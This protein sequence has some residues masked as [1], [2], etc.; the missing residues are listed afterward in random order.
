MVTRRAFLAYSGGTA[1]TLFLVG[2]NGIPQAVGQVAGGSLDPATV[3][4]FR[5]PLLAPPVMP[6]HGRLTAKGGRN[7]DYYEISMRQFSQQILPAGMPQTTVWGYGPARAPRRGTAI[8]HAPSLTIE[9]KWETPIRIKWV[10]ELVAA[11]GTYLP[12]LLPVDPTLHWAN[13]GRVPDE[14]GRARTDIRPSYAGKTYVAPAD[15]T[16]PTTQY[17]DYRGP[18]PIVAHVHGAVGV[19]EESDGYPEAWFLPVAA[20][21]PADHATVGHWYDF[22]AATFAATFGETW[23][24]GFSISHYPNLNRAST[25]WYHDHTLGM[26]RLN[27]Y[28]G[29]AGFFIL[30]GGPSGDGAV[31][32]S[33]TA[34]PAV[35]PGP[36][37]KEGDKATKTYRE[38]PLAIQDRSFNADG[39]L[40]Y[41]DTRAF[42]DEL[43]P[44]YIP[45]SDVSPVWNPEFFG[46][47]VMV[48]GRT[49]P[50]HQVEQAR[51]RFRVL[52]GCGSRFLI[53][54]FAAIP[55]VQV[56]QIGSEGG[57]LAGPVDVMATAGGKLLMAPAERADLIV[58]FTAVPIGSHVLTNVGPDA[59]FGGGVPGTD[60]DPADPQ[61]TGRVMQFRVV[62]AAAP[63]PSTPAAFL[64]LPPR[65][66]LPA[67]TVRRPLAL[68]EHMSSRPGHS[69]IAAMLG[70]VAGDPT[71]GWV[72]T[73]ARMWMDPITQNPALGA[74]EVW[75][76]YNTTADAHPIHVHEVAF[77]VVDRQ[78]IEVYVPPMEDHGG[79]TMAHPAPMVRVAPGSTP[80]PPEPTETNV[81]DTVIAYPGEVTR[82]KATFKVPGRFVWHCHIVEHEDNEMMLPLHVG[83]ARSGEPQP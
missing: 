25:L 4:Q 64:T 35:F 44:P 13:P 28:A 51:Y 49:W 3:P 78:A 56:H 60:F 53:L 14:Q 62:A 74:T 5:T 17:T 58:D 23:G 40:F 72:A 36:Y 8:H 45:A 48:N 39:S 10:N 38:I 15:F 31:L 34:A 65:P 77:E 69:P 1:L 59:P 67:A 11:D 2:G 70:D 42:F 63:D 29:P 76:F 71:T 21:L 30:R 80:R 24:P 61:T 46:N 19:G 47:T 7:A 83:P 79:M 16:D 20:N 12:H 57:F 22:H 26:T 81:K 66:S 75:E 37:P 52:N 68:I 55:G 43:P 18:V 6:L 73:R 9:A 33:R 32:D 27:V 41:P 50:F 54:D 82:I